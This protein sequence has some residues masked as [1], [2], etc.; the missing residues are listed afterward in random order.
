VTRRLLAA[1]LL[2]A[3]GPALAR[4]KT[5]VVVIQNGDVLTGEIKGMS[6]GKIDFSTDDAGRISIKWDKVL[7]VSSIHPYEV[8]LSSGA[9]HFGVLS[10]PSNEDLAVGLLPTQD[11]FPM[12]AVV[13]IVPMDDNFLGRVRA[14]FDFG[15]TFAKANSA[16]TISTSGELAY[17]SRS[18]GARLNFDGYFQTQS[19]A[20]NTTTVSQYSAALTGNYY[21]KQ[22]WRAFVSGQLFH[23]DELSLILRSTIASGAGYSAVRNGWN[24][25]WLTA[26][27][28][29][30]REQY[31]TGDPN[32]T[33]EGM[34]DVSWTAFRYDT[35][36]LDLAA[37]LVLLPG[38]TDWGRLRGTF[39]FRIK[40][41][42][43]KDFNT[44][45]QF[46][47]SFDTR[48]PDPNASHNDYITSLTVG[49]SYRK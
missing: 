46:T 13:E 36:K 48:P 9:R 45:L 27:L 28:A 2:V 23:N 35:P 15:F 4:E 30:S 19:D 42:F 32:F 17:R 21:F 44:G 33:L 5:D 37:E 14:A 38:L 3:A 34:F 41:E 25:L 43:F 16:T 8:E 49:W 40:Y 18:F 12:D 39:T 26:G 29:G 24:E 47:D 31:M 10:S 7:R 20:V 11:I 22:H 1:A 6:R